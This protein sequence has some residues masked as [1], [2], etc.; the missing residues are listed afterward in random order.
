V[1]ISLNLLPENYI[2]VKRDKVAIILLIV[3]VIL[4]IIGQASAYYI[5]QYI[6]KHTKVEPDFTKANEWEKKTKK[7]EQQIIEIKKQMKKEAVTQDQL[8]QVREKIEFLNKFIGQNSIKWSFFLDRLEKHSPEDMW[9]R[10][11]KKKIDE[12]D[13][14]PVFTLTCWAISLK[15]VYS[16]WSSLERDINFTEVLLLSE[17]EKVWL[18]SDK[19][20]KK[21]G[22][23]RKKK[24]RGKRAAVSPESP[25]KQEKP[26]KYVEFVLRFKYV[27]ITVLML[28]KR[29]ESIIKSPSV[30]ETYT[31]YGLNVLGRKVV[32]EPEVLKWELDNEKIGYIVEKEGRFVAKE[33]GEGTLTIS[34]PLNNLMVK[35]HI[36][37][38]E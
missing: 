25:E 36:K 19:S 5:I 11:I 28:P 38:M 30:S 12:T 18:P 31:V 13:G 32:I 20:K 29:L 15:E 7:L 23:K 4:S 33:P 27:P 8:W 34:Y 21:S 17:S 24:G 3:V 37:V 6:A 1:R 22:G 9:I 10:D 2:G 16:F 26:R 35:S 14:A